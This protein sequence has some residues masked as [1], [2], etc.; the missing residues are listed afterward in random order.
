MTALAIIIPFT[1]FKMSDAMIGPQATAAAMG[2]FPEMAGA[3]S[4]LIG[5]IRQITGASMAIIVGL[6]DDGTS[7]PMG[8]GIL[9][10][11]VGPLAIYYHFIRQGQKSD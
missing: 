6:I 10:A 11:G 2:P 7:F 8:V 4:S 9:I 1:T 3:A 5:F